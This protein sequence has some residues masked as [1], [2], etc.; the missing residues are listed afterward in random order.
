M[1]LPLISP[2]PARLH[3]WPSSTLW[4]TEEPFATR[5]FVPS[6][7]IS[8]AKKPANSGGRTAISS[9]SAPPWGSRYTKPFA[10]AGA[11]SVVPFRMIELTDPDVNTSSPVLNAVH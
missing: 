10:P 3:D 9:Q 6:L 7:F 4:Y 2:D 5:I 8:V 11:R 1:S